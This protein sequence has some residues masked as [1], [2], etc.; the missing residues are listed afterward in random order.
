MPS[1]HSPESDSAITARIAVEV[2]LRAVIEVR[3]GAPIVD[4]AERLGV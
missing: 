2:R 1:P 3:N 4:V